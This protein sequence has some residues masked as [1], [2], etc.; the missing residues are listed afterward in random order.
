MRLVVAPLCTVADDELDA[1]EV[2]LTRHTP[3][4]CMILQA[5]MVHS[6]LEQHLHFASCNARVSASTAAALLHFRNV[7]C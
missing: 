1:E 7:C 4:D 6:A 3:N 2:A 5:G